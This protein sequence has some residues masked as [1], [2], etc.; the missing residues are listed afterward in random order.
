VA[1]KKASN[2]TTGATKNLSEKQIRRIWAELKPLMLLERLRTIQPDGRWTV[3]GSRL[4]GR[5]P[6][7]NDDVTSFHVYLD[8]GYAKCFQCEKFLWNP[9][10]FWA[11]V[12]G[13]NWADALT[14]LRQ[15]FD[16]KFLS[17][18]AGA[19]LTTWDRNQYLKH[20]IAR[21][22]HDELINAIANPT[23]SDYAYAQSAVMYL[24]GTRQ[25]PKDTIPTLH[26][27]GVMPPLNKILDLLTAEAVE[28]NARRI[29]AA[30]DGLAPFTRF[31]SLVDEARVYLES[32]KSW[33]GSLV[34][35]LDVATDSI[36]RFK[37][38]RPDTDDVLFLADG[39]EEE[40]GFFG[41][42]WSLYKS[43]YGA[44]PKTTPGVHVV[45]EEFAALNAMARMV[46]AG[47]PTFIV[48]S[49][50]GA[51]GGPQLDSL[52]SIGAEELYIVGS[53]STATTN[54][55]TLVKQ[56]LP[57]VRRLRVRIFVGYKLFSGCSEPDEII[58]NLGLKAFQSVVL[59]VKDRAIFQPP[60][61]WVFDLYQPELEAID[62]SDLRLRVEKAVEGGRLL[63][64]GVECDAFVE[65]CAKAF[66]LPAATLK[67][68]IVAKEE[69]EPAFIMRLV[70]VLTQ[71]FVVI[72]QKANDSE[73]AI[74][75][76]H[77]EKRR[78]VYVTLADE[79]SIERQLGPLLGAL[80]QFLG[81]RVGI[82]TFLEPTDTEK[83]LKYLQ[84]MD[85]SIRWYMRQ[86]LII[87]AQDAPDFSTA[88]Q[89]AA[90]IHVLARE[91]GQTAPIL[92]MVNGRDV[93]HGVYDAQEKLIWTQLPGPSHNGIIFD[94]GIHH[95]EKTWAPWISSASDLQRADSIDLKD[96]WTR[97]HALVDAGWRYKNHAI[98]AQFLTSHIIATTVCDAFRRK[99]AVAF[100]ADT[101]A[102]KSK[103]VMGL[104]GGTDFSRIHILA[105]AV[106]MP[107]FTPAGIK[108][109]MNNKTRPLCL[110]EFEDEGT[111]E[112]KS[113]I[114]TE[115]YEL[116]RNLLGEN[117][118][119]TQGS[120]GGE[121]VNFRL[122]FNLFI[123]AINRARKTQDAN[124][125]VTVYM[126]RVDNRPDPVQ[127]LLQEYGEFYIDQ[128]KQDLSIALLPRIAQLQRAYAEIEIEFSQPGAR[129]SSIDSRIFEGLYQAMSVM[130]LLSMDYRQFAK[131][132][133][134]ANKE[135]LTVAAA[136]TDTMELFHWTTQ[137]TCIPTRFGEDGKDRRL[138]SVLQMLAT[139]ELRTEINISGTG[140]FFD[141][142]TQMLVVSWTMAIQRVLHLHPKY[143]KETNVFNLRELANRAPHA[144]KAEDL[145]RSGAL[146]RL[147]VQG[148][149]GVPTTH[150]TAYYMGHLIQARST[151]D[152]MLD[153][154][155]VV[156][157]LTSV[158]T[159]KGKDM[160]DDADFS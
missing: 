44:L 108:Q 70:D 95:P 54:G 82:P 25:V 71:I 5:C 67:R 90:G 36:G 97:T 150:L 89:R 123:A 43:M 2:K 10:E 84:K 138:A 130:K 85:A 61:E 68:E 105:A 60:Q 58:C 148:L 55:E 79:T 102:G 11:K 19:Q 45:E 15:Q 75:L 32:A 113:R 143:S 30:E 141:E 35:R 101:R 137:T 17:T 24:I 98:T 124:R 16:I 119:V 18:T 131:E 153:N 4:T 12:R 127:I 76:W 38:R 158:E 72:G 93:F 118:S 149:A 63:K 133:C 111:A 62:E 151:A 53:D 3:A 86:A 37:L 109:T 129:P 91:K 120:R 39:Y 144:V 74:Y 100:H 157:A 41:L 106:G 104:L 160:V 27:L 159:M 155:P 9:V 66:G 145:E 57:E 154:P 23:H 92:Y 28:E 103:M 21:I 33:T 56:W 6:Y 132:F 1:I 22:C 69:D 34:F 126:E 142:P 50:D 13:T 47:G 125:M 152:A 80:Y 135:V 110:D 88:E 14:E 65:A 64:N 134:E 42:S 147:R 73:R 112:K 117:N 140:L 48:L 78:I 115:S 87:M 20:S 52:Y 29:Q 40:H 59:N 7:H 146:S 121:A 49:A 26:M 107:S 116:F 77:K 96:L 156:N 139:P 114:V 51:S 99:V 81:E 94:V 8:R 122:V 31:T 128:L 46:E 136:T 83:Q